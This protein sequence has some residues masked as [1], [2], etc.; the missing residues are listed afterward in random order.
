MI[1]ETHA[2]PRQTTTLHIFAPVCP[3][4]FRAQTFREAGISIIDTNA[5]FDWRLSESEKDRDAITLV[6]PLPHEC[7]NCADAW[8]TC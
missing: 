6:V 5:G 7:P 3:M 4:T 8:I 1:E 2:D